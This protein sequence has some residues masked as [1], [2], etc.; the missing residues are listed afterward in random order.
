MSECCSCCN[1]EACVWPVTFILITRPEL[2][3]YLIHQYHLARKEVLGRQELQPGVSAIVPPVKMTQ[4]KSVCL[5]AEP[6]QI[7]L[8]QQPVSISGYKGPQHGWKHPPAGWYFR[9]LDTLTAEYLKHTRTS[10]ANDANI[11]LQSSLTASVE[12]I[13]QKRDS[14]GAQ[15][16]ASCWEQGDRD[17]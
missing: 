13:F 2:S 12:G 9:L 3:N 10:P 6:L 8:P 1:F 17:I 5:K 15:A 11:F 7:E 4:V 14:R 16:Q